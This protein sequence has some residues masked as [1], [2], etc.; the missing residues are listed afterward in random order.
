MLEDLPEGAQ[1]DEKELAFQV[2]LLTPLF[3]TRFGSAEGE[4]AA[5]RALEL[6][7]K[8]GADQWVA[9]PG[10]VWAD[11]DLFGAWENPD[12]TRGR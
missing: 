10:T 8:I 2:A 6:S 3:A 9:F 4:H 12:R 5:A 11:D 1:R 7:R